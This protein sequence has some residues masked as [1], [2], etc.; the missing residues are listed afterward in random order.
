MFKIWRL[1]GNTTLV[2]TGY[3]YVGSLWEIWP[4]PNA[5]SV[6]GFETGPVSTNY[7]KVI[8]P[9]S[10]GTVSYILLLEYCYTCLSDSVRQGIGHS[11]KTTGN[12]PFTEFTGL[13]EQFFEPIGF[14]LFDG[15]IQSENCFHRDTPSVN[16]TKE[17]RST[18]F[19]PLYSRPTEATHKC[20]SLSSLS[21]A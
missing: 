4:L 8:A 19:T 12:Q 20:L 5:V 16:E 13:A 1:I 2:Q 10:E 14:Y 21:T 17:R 6:L 7:K 9:T 15:Q 11:A 18:A 3:Y